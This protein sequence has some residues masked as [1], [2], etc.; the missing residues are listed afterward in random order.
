MPQEKTRKT[1]FNFSM[2]QNKMENDINNKTWKRN[3]QR[4]D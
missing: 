2:Q 4:H 1:D 3:N